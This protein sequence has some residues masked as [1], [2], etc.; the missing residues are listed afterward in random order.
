MASPMEQVS[1]ALGRYVKILGTRI[2]KGKHDEENV[3]D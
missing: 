1:L 2:T 3:S